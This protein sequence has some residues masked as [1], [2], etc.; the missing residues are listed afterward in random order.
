MSAELADEQLGF[1]S[2]VAA[3]RIA[4]LAPR[5]NA[6]EV[7]PDLDRIVFAQLVRENECRGSIELRAAE[8]VAACVVRDVQLQ[9]AAALPDFESRGSLYIVG[10]HVV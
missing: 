9:F 6:V 7:P 8:S 1:A 2:A 3:V 10:R 4:P 5:F